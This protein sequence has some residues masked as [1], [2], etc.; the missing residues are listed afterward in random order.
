MVVAVIPKAVG[1]FS[2]W[3]S[4][5]LFIF[6]SAKTLARSKAKEER[7]SILR[8]GFKWISLE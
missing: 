3:V 4:D 5:F 8:K 6:V 1:L 2:L 7:H